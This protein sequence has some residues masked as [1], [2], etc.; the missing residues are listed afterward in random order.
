MDVQYR[1][2]LHQARNTH[3]DFR[4]HAA[5]GLHIHR[6]TAACSNITAGGVG[7]GG[8]DSR[9]RGRGT[10]AHH[11]CCVHAAA[12]LALRATPTAR[13]C[14]C[15][16][17]RRRTSACVVQDTRCALLHWAGVVRCFV[18][19]WRAAIACVPL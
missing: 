5:V 17:D 18:E 16:V 12:T 13:L 7:Q 11:P 1:A 9:T 2:V 15:P 3:I 10:T 4:S 19:C 14:A 6:P 8:R